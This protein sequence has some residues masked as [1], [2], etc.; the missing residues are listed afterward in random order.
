[1]PREIDCFGLLVPTLLPVFIACIGLQWALDTLLTRL[2]AYRNAWHP[3]LLRLALFG[4]L[5]GLLSLF[6]YPA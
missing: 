3:A 2:G 6:I 4:C 1:M 5:F